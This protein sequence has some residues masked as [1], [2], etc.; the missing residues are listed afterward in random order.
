MNPEP[1]PPARRPM[2]QQR[3]H[4][5]DFDRARERRIRRAA[6]RQGWRISK[7]RTR[8]D[9]VP[10]WGNWILATSR[11][12]V[13]IGDRATGAPIEAVEDFL[14]IE[15]PQDEQQDEQASGLMWIST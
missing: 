11:G 14:G 4:D 2:A 10:G 12:R 15:R 7:I 6:K 1:E 13:L 9:R 3:R 5:A 8:D